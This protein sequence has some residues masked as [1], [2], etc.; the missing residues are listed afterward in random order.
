VSYSAVFLKKMSSCFFFIM[1]EKAL[2]GTIVWRLKQSAPAL[3]HS[4]LSSVHGRRSFIHHGYPLAE[5]RAQVD[6]LINGMIF[7]ILHAAPSS[8]PI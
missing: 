7:A 5:V 2:L 1:A 4:T 8:G 3:P 6:D